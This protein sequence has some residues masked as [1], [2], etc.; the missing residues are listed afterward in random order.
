ME[1]LIPH[2]RLWL[3]L[4]YLDEEQRQM[5]ITSKGQRSDVVL[6]E[7]RQSVFGSS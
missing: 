5:R 2:D 7:L 4:E 6:A 3:S 1:A